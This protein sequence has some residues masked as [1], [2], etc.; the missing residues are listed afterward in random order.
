MPR[1]LS[2]RNFLKLL[3]FTTE[4][5][6]YLVDLS[7]ELKK[8]KMAGVPH[9]WLE[10]KN[11]VLLFEKTSTR[12]RCSFEVAGMD[13]GMGVT[14]LD[15]GSSQMG[16][17]ESIEDTA[18]VL[19]RMYDGIEYRGFAQSICEELAANAGVPV[20]NGLTTEFHPTQMIADLLTIEENFGTLKGL[21]F[22]FMGDAGNNVGNSLMVA[23]AKMGLNFTACGP[24]E[25]MPDAELIEECK[26][27]AAL[28][29][30]TVR[31]TEDVEEGT[32]GAHVI[33]TD[34]WVSMGEPA[35]LWAERIR[36]LHPYQVNAK[37]MANAA[38]NAIFM[39]CLPSF[40]D[41]KTTIGAEI[42]EKF[43][44]T[45]MEV[46]DEVFESAQSKVFDEAEN[47][48]HTIKAVMYATLK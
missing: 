31:V 18:R 1:S 14:Y 37:V 17:K 6:R 23:C 24:K 45:E 10:G 27:I 22:V 40:H 2:G 47:R 5:I 30:A 15:P 26:K 20:W 36:L 33:Y 8:L 46:S 29:G 21:N 44:L 35:E 4:E 39:H 9:R 12:T 7:K 3:D 34:I 28:N 32:K 11:I 38:P 19:G 13:L 43:G 25:Q 42:H 16:K 41:L 48:M